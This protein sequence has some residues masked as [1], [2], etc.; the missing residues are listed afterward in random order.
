MSSASSRPTTA[1]YTP[2]VE[3]RPG[4]PA[5]LNHIPER[6]VR[7]RGQVG[8]ITERQR[9]RDKAL[10]GRAPP[11]TADEAEHERRAPILRA[12]TQD[13]LVDLL[14][15]SGWV[16]SPRVDTVMRALDRGIFVPPAR[17]NVCYVDEPQPLPS[18]AGATISQPRVHALAL[19]ALAPAVFKGATCLDVGAGSGLITAA[20]ALMAGPA[21]LVI[22]VEV[23]P[24]LAELAA[25]NIRVWAR[26]EPTGAFMDAARTIELCVGDGTAGWTKG[27]TAKLYDVI[28]VGA[29]A[30][31]PPVALLQQLRPGGTLVM[32]VSRPGHGSKQFLTVFAKDARGRVVETPLRRC[33]FVPLL[34]SSMPPIARTVFSGRAWVADRLKRA[35]AAAVEARSRA[36][37]KIARRQAQ[38]EARAA[39]ARAKMARLGI[40]PQAA[41]H[42]AAVNDDAGSRIPSPSSTA[43]PAGFSVTGVDGGNAGTPS[44]RDAGALSVTTFAAQPRAVSPSAASVVPPLPLSPSS[45]TSRR[46]ASKAQ[47]GVV[48]GAAGTSAGQQGPTAADRAT[49][50]TITSQAFS[51]VSH[52][53][54]TARRDAQ[55]AASKGVDGSSVLDMTRPVSREQAVFASRLIVRTRQKQALRA[56]RAAGAW[57]PPS[58]EEQSRMTKLAA[59]AGSTS[60]QGRAAPPRPGGVAAR[61]H[62]VRTAAATSR[63]GA[64][65]RPHTATSFA[66]SLG[67]ALDRPMPYWRY[68]GRPKPPASSVKQAED[69]IAAMRDPG[70][71]QAVA[72]G[73]ETSTTKKKREAALKRKQQEEATWRTWE[74]AEFADGFE[75]PGLDAT[76]RPT[77]APTTPM[78][79]LGSDGGLGLSWRLN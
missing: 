27:M 29:A 26:G 72:F 14:A 47:A 77:T 25:H 69:K 1:T 45:R 53:G 67:G 62:R 6:G 15:A 65:R 4:S 20:L 49:S 71:G 75:M 28:H 63:G 19:E 50:R 43:L 68:I 59:S 70:Y 12:A 11:L 55:V 31:E 76:S 2:A 17:S 54:D 52:R 38:R 61:R 7:Q 64:A 74:A 24:A 3:H 56:A 48:A 16:T 23:W 51:L 73:Q 8:Q 39:E 36:Q 10:T 32:P 33:D 9:L 40:G 35:K 41:L 42:V 79:G 22:G 46:R 57:S 34:P 66:M 21:G 78:A 5:R 30:P 44:A 18:G 13:G 58:T 37:A 60:N